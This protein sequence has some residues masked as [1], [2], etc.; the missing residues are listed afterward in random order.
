MLVLNEHE[1]CPYAVRCPYSGNGTTKCQ[2]TNPQ[3]NCTFKCE[4][5]QSDGRICDGQQR[6]SLDKTGKME[7]L[8][9]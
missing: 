6:S 5:V 9:D 4:Y 8:I 2:G 3:R 1:T 7:L